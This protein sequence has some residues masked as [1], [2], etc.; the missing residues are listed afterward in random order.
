MVSPSNTLSN[1]KEDSI[2]QNFLCLLKT[3]NLKEHSFYIILKRI[4]EGNQVRKQGWPQ[5][6]NLGGEVCRFYLG[7]EQGEEC[8]PGAETNVALAID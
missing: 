2:Q 8:S 1:Q 6:E 4:I 7:G 5:G 3:T